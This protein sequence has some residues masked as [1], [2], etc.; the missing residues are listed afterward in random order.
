MKTTDIS[1]RSPLLPERRK[2]DLFIC[3]ILDAAPKGDMASMEHPI[4]SLAT[5]PD[6]KV[7]KY[8]NNGNTIE[9][10]PS[11]DGM[12]TIH[13]RDI[14]I[15]CISQLIAAKNQDQQITQLVRFKAYDLLTATNRSKSGA[16]YNQLKAALERLAGTRITTNIV[17]GGKTVFHTF[18]LVES[19]KIVR[20]NLDGRMQDIEIKISDWIWNA[21]ETKEVLTLHKDYFRLRKPLERRIYEIARKHCGSKSSWKISIQKLHLKCGSLSTSREFL[22]LVKN[23]IKQDKESSHI[24]DYSMDIEDGMVCFFNRNTMPSVIEYNI[25]PALKPKTYE[26]AKELAPR[27]DIRFLENEWRA[28]SKEPPK[29]ADKAFLGFC[30]DYNNRHGAP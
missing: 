13:D 30:R 28:W 1:S 26:D 25:I 15:Y 9:I 19:A 20:E 10:K 12:A 17:S 6:M 29:N 8:E 7:R 5:K 27:Y 18:G 21:I 23:I 2:Q 16:S 22:R 3:D 4:F 14:L 11:S 24:P